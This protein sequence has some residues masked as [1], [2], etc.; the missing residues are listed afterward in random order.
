MPLLSAV[1]NNLIAVIEILIDSGAD[2][3]AGNLVCTY[4]LI[5]YT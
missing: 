1:R 4:V 2:T 5:S 3:N